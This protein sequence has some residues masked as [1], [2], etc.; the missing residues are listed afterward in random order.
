[1]ETKKFDELKLVI[2]KS[3]N[4]E[5][6]NP[7]EEEREFTDLLKS[8]NLSIKTVAGRKK[9]VWNLL[10]RTTLACSLDKDSI[11]FSKTR[12]ATFDGSNRLHVHDKRNNIS[13]IIKRKIDEGVSTL[14]QVFLLFDSEMEN[15][16]K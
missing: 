16:F 13:P 10:N 8:V 15:H 1:M 2:L 11:Y 14:K 4:S 3:Q 5:I 6:F 12:T 9:I 7:T